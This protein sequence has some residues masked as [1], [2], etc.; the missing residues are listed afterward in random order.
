MVVV[1]GETDVVT[2]RCACCNLKSRNLRKCSGC[3]TRWYCSKSCQV[4]DWKKRHK[5]MCKSLQQRDSFS[6]GDGPLVIDAVKFGKSHWKKNSHKMSSIVQCCKSLPR[7]GGVASL[8]AVV[9]WHDSYLLNFAKAL[10]V[11]SK[12]E[13]AE[14]HQISAVKEYVRLSWFNEMSEMQDIPIFRYAFI[15]LQ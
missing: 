12:K 14:E 6:D 10:C 7:C 9:Q 2:G 11:F 4:N 13:D 8:W 15:F 1:S 3:L 5:M